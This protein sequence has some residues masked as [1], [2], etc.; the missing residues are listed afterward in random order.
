MEG[1]NVMISQ[2]FFRTDNHYPKDECPQSSVT[3]SPYGVYVHFP[4]ICLLASQLYFHYIILVGSN[5]TLMN[6][7]VHNPKQNVFTQNST[8]YNRAYNSLTI[9]QVKLLSR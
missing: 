1:R 4:W 7:D 2:Y 3:G 6:T 8:E 5:T 9:G